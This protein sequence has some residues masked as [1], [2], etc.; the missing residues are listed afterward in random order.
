VRFFADENV[1]QSI[2]EWLRKQKHDIRSASEE[3]PGED[4]SVW[5]KEAQD[6]ERIILTS[7]KDFGELIFRDRLNSHGIVLTLAERIERLQAVWSVIEANPSGRFVVISELKVRVRRLKV[8]DDNQA[9]T[10]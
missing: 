3:E 2:V 5:L 7:D 8:D 6:D 10:R 4:D 9:A 1:A